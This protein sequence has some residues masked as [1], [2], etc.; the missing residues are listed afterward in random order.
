MAESLPTL[1]IDVVTPNDSR[2]EPSVIQPCT[3][4]PYS[5]LTGFAISSSDR[6]GS[7][8]GQAFRHAV[9]GFKLCTIDRHDE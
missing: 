9:K 1:A 4:R 2:F 6:D 7:N 3:D 5:V 8:L